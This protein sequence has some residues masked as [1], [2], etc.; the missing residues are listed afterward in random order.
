MYCSKC[1]NELIKEAAFCSNCGEMVRNSKKT[2]EKK[3]KDKEIETE[4]NNEEIEYQ[5]A[6]QGKRFVDFLIDYILVGRVFIPFMVVLLFPYGDELTWYVANII[7][8][9]L[10]FF[11]F[12]TFT[13]KTLGKLIT[14]TKVLNLLDEKPSAGQI[15][16]R[17]LSR[18]IPFEAF[19]YLS[20]RPVGWHDTISKTYVIEKVTN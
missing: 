7:F 17:T 2:G 12:E 1:G 18:F 8:V 20:S 19:S 4:T 16:I 3:K 11:L 14:R 15:I 9:I 6:S 5:K 10:Y 13:G